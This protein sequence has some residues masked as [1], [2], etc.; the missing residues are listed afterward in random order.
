MIELLSSPEVWISLLTLTSLE[1]VLGIDNV[2]FIAIL[3]G[4]LPAEQQEKAR[5]LGL[6]GALVTRLALLSVIS[7]IVQLDSPL[8]QIFGRDIS[9]KSI[10]LMI[11][12]LFLLYKAT[13]EIH[14]KLE[15]AGDQSHVTTKV[16][17]MGAVIGQIM[18]LDIVFS[19]DSVIT[20]VGLSPYISVMVLAN[21][22]ALGVMLLAAK[23][24]SDFVETHP[25]LKVLALSFLLMIGLVLLA[26]GFGLHIPKGYVYFA[27]GFSVMVE[28]INIKAA[29]RKKRK[30]SH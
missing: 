18:L 16:S 25:S 27:M 2:I 12:G 13:R 5:K 11:G 4:K 24:I 19:I 14:H 1:I 26:E 6:T 3:A 22:I 9:W 29:S 23:T 17:T 30:Q 28:F 21:I 15:G 10:I 7:I 20:A 8:F